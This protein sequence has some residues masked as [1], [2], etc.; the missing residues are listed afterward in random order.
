MGA[1]SPQGGGGMSVTSPSPH[2]EGD[3][4]S[5]FWLIWWVMASG[6]KYKGGVDE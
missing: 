2:K 4:T 6:Y 5:F 1:H 3:A